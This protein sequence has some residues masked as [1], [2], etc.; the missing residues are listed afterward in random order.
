MYDSFG[1]IRNIENI[2]Q[3]EN[4]LD[5]SKIESELKD[6]INQYK[7]KT[8]QNRNY[9]PIST[10]LLINYNNYN[11][12]YVPIMWV[13]QDISN[14]N[15]LYNSLMSVLIHIYKIRLL[16]KNEQQIKLFI[17]NNNLQLIDKIMKMTLII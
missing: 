17:Y 8:L 3:F 10:S 7:F 9:L 6:K 15:N 4:H 14:T 2:N 16:S 5:I 13:K 1:N 11:I 12:L